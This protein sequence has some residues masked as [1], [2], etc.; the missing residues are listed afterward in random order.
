MRALS[1]V[2]SAWLA[3]AS[4]AAAVALVACSPEGGST[5]ASPPSPSEAMGEAGSPT[6]APPPPSASGPEPAVLA[7]GRHPVYL[8][9]LDASKRRITFDLI[10]FL[11]GETAQKAWIKDH[12]EEPDGPPN[13]YLIVNENVKLRTLPVSSAVTVKVLNTDDLTAETTPIPFAD[14]PAHLTKDLDKT[15]KY[16]WVLPF[17]L[18]VMQ[19]QVVLIEEQ[20]LP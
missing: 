7:D 8:T 2:G 5:D 17:W 12:P 13:D 11:T 1:R 14:F 9:G 20:F 19:G 18:T 6:A 4:V 15:D 10:Q 16:L 3:A